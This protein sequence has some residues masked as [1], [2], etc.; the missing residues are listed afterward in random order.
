MFNE[1]HWDKSKIPLPPCTSR[2]GHRINCSPCLWFIISQS[3]GS[4]K[5]SDSIFFRICEYKSRD[6]HPTLGQYLRHWYGSLTD[7]CDPVHTRA[8]GGSLSWR[9][10]GWDRAEPQEA[11]K[12]GNFLGNV[13]QI[14]LWDTSLAV[15]CFVNHPTLK[16]L[17]LPRNVAVFLTVMSLKFLVKRKSASWPPTE[18]MTQATIQ[19]RADRNPVWGGER[20]SKL[21]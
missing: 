10:W 14:K 16:T 3:L 19:G 6:Y 18:P 20:P 2:N 1:R 12:M 4:Q 21:L 11:L 9:N 17:F 7:T 15:G 13:K 5:T 8:S